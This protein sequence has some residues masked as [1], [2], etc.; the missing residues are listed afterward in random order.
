MSPTELNAVARLVWIAEHC[1]RE[2]LD[3]HGAHYSSNVKS[4]EDRIAKFTRPGSGA[5]MTEN[6]A[7]GVT[8]LS[9]RLMTGS[10]LFG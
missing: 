3:S 4:L 7:P 2:F 9:I 10:N 8:R 1:G 5:L 6:P